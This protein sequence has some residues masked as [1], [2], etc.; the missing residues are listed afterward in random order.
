MEKSTRARGVKTK[1]SPR[2]Q[3]VKVKKNAEPQIL[4]RY[5][6]IDPGIC[7]GKPTFRGTRIMVADVLEQVADGLAWETIIEEWR[8]SV[9]KEAIAEAV[10]LAR[11]A[12]LKHASEFSLN[13]TPA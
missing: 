1:K 10:Q 6:I 8:G 2:P 3:G 11:E 5:I 12:F 9:T 13:L 4:G 7:H